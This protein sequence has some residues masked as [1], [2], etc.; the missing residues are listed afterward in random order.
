M[1]L[2]GGDQQGAIQKLIDELFKRFP[3]LSR[4]YYIT[5]D[6]IG[7][8]ATASDHGMFKW[9]ENVTQKHELQFPANPFDALL[10]KSYLFT[11]MKLMCLQIQICELVCKCMPTCLSNNHGTDYICIVWM[12]MRNKHKPFFVLIGG[13]VLISGTGSNCKLVNPDGTQIGC[14]GWG[15]IMGDEGSGN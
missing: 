10:F 4:S 3:K 6:A 15:H 8:M 11:T 14:G 12:K 9:L 7:A 5:T 13:I 1:S 2:S